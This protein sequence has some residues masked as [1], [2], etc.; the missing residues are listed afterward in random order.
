MKLTTVFL[1][2]TLFVSA[3][4]VGIKSQT[5]MQLQSTMKKLNQSPWGQV[6]AS[7]LDL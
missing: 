2:A 3:W 7:F 6:A 5:N 4:S 1:I